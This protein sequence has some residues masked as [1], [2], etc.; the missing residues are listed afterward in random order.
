MCFLYFFSLP[1]LSRRIL[2][3]PES[4]KDT[5]IRNRRILNEVRGTIDD[6]KAGSVDEGS[7][8]FFRLLE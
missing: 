1:I 3:V 8:S 4:K 2:V 7:L 6:L 5:S